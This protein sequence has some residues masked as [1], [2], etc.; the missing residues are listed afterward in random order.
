M[1]GPV[2]VLCTIEDGLIPSE[3]I[4]RVQGADGRVEEVSV[5]SRNVHNDRL[6][7]FAIGADEGRVLLE[8]PRES[9]S[10]RWRVWVE[11]TLVTAG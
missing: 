11:N 4:V 7:V 6:D 3:R 9:A 10:G 1:T 8:L 5:S 2:R